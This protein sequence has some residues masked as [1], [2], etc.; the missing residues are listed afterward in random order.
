MP[1]QTNRAVR[2]HSAKMANFAKTTALTTA[3][4]AP[5]L[6]VFVLFLLSIFHVG[7]SADQPFYLADNG[8]RRC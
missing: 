7:L 3:K 2:A 6:P 5:F 1:A 8:V 4:K